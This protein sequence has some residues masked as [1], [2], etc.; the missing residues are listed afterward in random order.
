MS[1][2]CPPLSWM[3][4]STCRL[5]CV[6]DIKVWPLFC[7]NIP[8]VNTCNYAPM[9]LHVQSGRSEIEGARWAGDNDEDP[10]Q[11]A[12]AHLTVNPITPA[13]VD[14]QHRSLSNKR[15]IDWLI[16]CK[17]SFALYLMHSK[18]YDSHFT[19]YYIEL[20][21]YKT[22]EPVAFHGCRKDEDGADAL[23]GHDFPL[24][25]ALSVAAGAVPGSPWAKVVAVKIMFERYQISEAPAR[26]LPCLSSG[27]NIY[28]SI[29][30]VKFCEFVW[31]FY[32]WWPCGIHHEYVDLKAENHEFPYTNPAP[33]CVKSPSPLWGKTCWWSQR[34]SLP[35]I[36]SKL[37]RVHT[38]HHP[39]R[40]NAGT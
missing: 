11:Y 13:H 20:L 5:T 7:Q 19:K 35:G 10:S 40:L 36:H 4:F 14:L 38:Q 8:L 32:V 1:A 12:I 33:K 16:D 30:F 28:Y 17:H 26:S 29:V 3:A 21:Q 9:R 24:F 37:L 18:V 25:V 2:P 23:E 39:G 6:F 34:S 22:E 15:L 27:K 31:R